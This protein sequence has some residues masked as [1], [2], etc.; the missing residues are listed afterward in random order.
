MKAVDDYRFIGSIAVRPPTVRQ[1][2]ETPFV[3][4]PS[5]GIPSVEMPL[6][7]LQFAMT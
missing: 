7:S 6:Y 4:I 2:T 3:G 5:V 1:S